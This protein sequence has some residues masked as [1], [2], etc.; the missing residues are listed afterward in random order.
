MPTMSA[1]V[2]SI[3]VVA[4]GAI[5]ALSGPGRPPALPSMERGDAS[6]AARLREGS[7]P[8]PNSLLARDGVPLAYRFYEGRPGGGVAV[9]VHGSTGTMVEVHV[10]ARALA[11]G[12]IGAYAIDLRGHGASLGREGL[13][14][15]AHRGQL[16]EDM[17]DLL[18]LIAR[19]H[20]GARP[21]LIG[22]SLGGSFVLKIAAGRLA[23][24][25]AGV[26]ALSPLI[27]TGNETNRPDTGGWAKVATPRIIALHALESMGIAALGGLPVITYAVPDD[28]GPDRPRVYSYRL[29]ADMLPPRDW[30]AALGAIAIP[31]RVMIGA[32]DELFLASRYGALVRVANPAIDMDVLP[33][34]DHMGMV[35]AEAPTRALAKAAASMIGGR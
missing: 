17:E 5:L 20:P 28:A 24:R 22:H 8:A 23:P 10:A 9:L 2:A 1:I 4:A 30:R 14:D 26:I 21:L 27:T 32:D 35:L 13:G 6:I 3:L 11:E 12:G 34:I 33:A 16:E 25:L 7:R 18:A 31:A 29:L 19:D 15:I